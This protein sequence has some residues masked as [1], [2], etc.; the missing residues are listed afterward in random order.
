MNSDSIL[1]IL[2]AS[3]PS[4]SGYVIRSEKIL[5]YLS[6]YGY[7][8][9]VVGSIF[10]KRIEQLGNGKKFSHN[11]RTYI[12]LLSKPLLKVLLFSGK[13]P[14]IRIVS[15]YFEILINTI[16]II[17][18]I[19]IKDYS[20]IHGHS[21]FRNGIS[22]Y[23][24][25]SVYKKPFIY[26]IHALGID[27]LK[28][29]TLKYR[30]EYFMEKVLIKNAKAIISIDKN[31]AESIIFRFNIDPNLVYIAPNGIDID[32]FKKP[33]YDSDIKSNL[34]IPF[35]KTILGVDNSKPLEGF[36]LITKSFEKI[37]NCISNVHFLVFGN[38][39]P[40]IKSSY[41][42]YLSQISPNNMPSYYNIVDLFILPR[43]KNHQSDTVT[44]LKVLELM[45]CETPVLTSNVGGLT[46][47]IK[48][49][50]T[51]YILEENNTESLIK[52]IQFALRDNNQKNIIANAKSWVI[53]NKSWIRSIAE[54]RDCYDDIIKLD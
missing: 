33:N 5:D 7:K 53:K 38:K 21:T 11:G 1:H 49:G 18:R 23:I 22:A 31:L 16:L 20:I 2:H 35:D 24:I 41:I 6:D 30:L 36:D 19:R 54:Y 14:I 12:Q 26:D 43:V 42:T 10:S 13:I 47:C 29:R 45:S 8:I 15:R 28:P 39:S 48:N 52:G 32:H 37:T 3:F 27:A 40:I 50:V 25:A 9:D 46:H 4:Q 34:G 51:G 44:P 17:V